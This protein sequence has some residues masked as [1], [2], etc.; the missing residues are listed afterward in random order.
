MLIIG[1]TGG[2]GT[3]KSEVARLLGQLGA[4]IIDADKVAHQ[5]YAPYTETWQRL[6]DEFGREVLDLD[7]NVDRK[8]L[9]DIVFGDSAKLAR[10]NAITHPVIIEEVRER[11][12]ALERDGA[13]VVVVEALRLD[14]GL[15]DLVDE[16]WVTAAD[17]GQVVARVGLR[18]GLAADE[19]L[20]RMASQP[21]ADAFARA[22]DVVVENRGSLA[23]LKD[24]VEALW[25]SRVERRKR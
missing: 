15:A 17:E 19:V 22:A 12:L 9:G 8:K 24:Q 21:P 4:A 5:V 10:L 18:S 25:K 1:L 2:I 14:T 13:E 6:V 7:G 16:V 3:G 23:E 20:K 11:L